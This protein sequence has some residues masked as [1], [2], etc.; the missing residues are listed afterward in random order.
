MIRYQ[1]NQF[2]LDIYDCTADMTYNCGEG[3]I[4]WL[5]AH[6]AES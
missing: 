5:N 4:N 1:L 2:G 6:A 3:I